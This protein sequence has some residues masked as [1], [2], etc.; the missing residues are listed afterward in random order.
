MYSEP[1]GSG[2]SAAL[3]STASMIILRS[4]PGSTGGSRSRA[5]L[6]TIRSTWLSSRKT[7]SDP[8]AWR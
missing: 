7:A 8:S 5:A 1:G 2:T 3:A 6:A 4:V